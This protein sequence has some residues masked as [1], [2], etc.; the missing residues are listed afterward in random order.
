MKIKAYLLKMMIETTDSRNKLR[1]KFNLK[2]E[3]EKIVKNNNNNR[4]IMMLKEKIWELNNLKE[5]KLI[6]FHST[7]LQIKS[8]KGTIKKMEKFNIKLE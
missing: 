5:Q 6:H 3:R 4:K 1:R 8:M 7:V 2:T